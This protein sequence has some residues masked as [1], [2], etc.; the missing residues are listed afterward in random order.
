RQC[1]CSSEPELSEFG[2]ELDPGDCNM[3]CDGTIIGESCGGIHKMSVYEITSY[4]GCDSGDF[5]KQSQYASPEDQ[6]I[7]GQLWDYQQK[8]DTTN[9]FMPTQS[10]VSSLTNASFPGTCNVEDDH[11]KLLTQIDVWDGAEKGAPRI[12]CGIY[13]HE[14]N[15]ATK[16][17]AVKET[18][19]SHCDGFVAFSDVADL[20][21]QTFKIK[22]EGPEEYSNMWQK[23]RAIW[24]YINFHYKDDFDW[25][26]L[27][28]DDLFLIVENLRKYLLSEEIKRAAGGLGN[29]GP[30]PMYLGRRFRFIGENRIYNNGGPSYVLNQASVGLLASH[31]DDDACQPHAAKHWEDILVASCLKKNGVEAFDTRDAL[32]RE[33]FHPF[34]PAAHFG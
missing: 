15:H 8:F 14:K 30:N 9:F 2:P 21:L 22:H 27:G 11:K 1:W 17:K 7:M 23:A 5:D 32:G 12:F 26:V 34:T 4:K 24:K 25:F 16:V 29:G 10:G 13:T 28:G 6:Q 33:R 18:W 19:A 3:L 31:L 20:E